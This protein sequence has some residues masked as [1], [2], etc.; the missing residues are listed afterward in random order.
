MSESSEQRSDL[1]ALR[2]LGRRFKDGGSFLFRFFVQAS[3]RRRLWF[4]FLLIILLVIFVGLV[5]WPKG[6]DLRVGGFFREIKLHLGL[7]LQGGTHLVYKMDLGNLTPER[8]DDAIAGARDVIERRVNAYGVG[9][10]VVQTTKVGDQWRLIVELPGVQDIQDAIAMIGATPYLEFRQAQVFKASE[11]PP[12]ALAEVA[13][14]QEIGPDT[15]LTAFVPTALTGKEF[16]HATVQFDPNTGSPVIGLQFNE[17]GKKLFAEI[18]QNNVGKQVAIY[19]DGQLISAPRV[20][21]PITTGEAI[22]TGDFT[23]EEAKELATRL[24]SGALPVPISLISQK[25]IGAS[26]GEKS[27]AQSV[28]AGMVGFLMVAL[29]MISF[30]RLPGLLAVFALLI[31]ILLSLA[32]FKLIPVT[33]TL[34]GIAGFLLS[35]GM[36][37]DANVL[38]FERMKEELRRGQNLPSALSIGFSRAWPSIRDSNLT[39]L[40]TCVILAYFGASIIRGFAI[41]LA[42]GVLVSMFTAIVVS[43]NFLSLYIMTFP[44]V[45]KLLGIKLQES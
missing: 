45:K 27:L 30:Y 31:Y 28:V 10:P 26:L 41:T 5:D 42:I 35:I 4:A 6:P 20:N 2:S 37:V 7:D 44:R 23:V 13:P 32:I 14:G 3:A 15:E 39:T 38:I 8:V 36:S 18:T 1:D 33:L 25:N 34:A 29:L 24:N 9:E 12:E 22:I 17:E 16:E 19:L 11:L 43:R 21:E 40:L